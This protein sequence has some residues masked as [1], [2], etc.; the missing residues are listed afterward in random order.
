M[1]L[2]QGNKIHTY[3]KGREYDTSVENVNSR[4]TQL[5]GV[6]RASF[7]LR[8]TLMKTEFIIP[9]STL[10]IPIQSHTQTRLISSVPNSAD[11]LDPLGSQ[12]AR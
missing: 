9:N 3:T 6:I 8:S 4:R 11:A 2:K 5:H 7:D 12:S 10:P 1:S